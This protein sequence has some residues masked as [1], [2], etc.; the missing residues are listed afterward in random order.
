MDSIR[1]NPMLPSLNEASGCIRRR[2]KSH[3]LKSD[4]RFMP[5]STEADPNSKREAAM[6][7]QLATFKTYAS[8]VPRQ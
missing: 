5:V 3:K 1:E 6:D 7:Q 2:H 8:P 4:L